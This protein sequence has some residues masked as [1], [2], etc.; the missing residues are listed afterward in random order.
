MSEFLSK[1]SAGEIIGLVAVVGGLLCGIIAVISDF[2][3]KIRKSDNV[4]RLKQD[5]LDRGMSAAEIQTIID[6]GAKNP[7]SSARE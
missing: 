7:A 1:F 5:M 4:T 2:F 3:Y 6:A